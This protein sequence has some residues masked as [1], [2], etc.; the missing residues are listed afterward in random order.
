MKFS[1]PLTKLERTLGFVY[2]L[3]QLFVLPSILNLV[4]ACL[5]Q[6]LSESSLNL[7]FFCINF[8]CVVAIF[9]RFLWKSLLIAK[10]N[11]WRCLRY[12]FLGYALYYIGNILVTMGIQYL[13]PD[14]YNINDESVMSMVQE[15]FTLLSMATVF[16][17]PVVEECLFRGVMFRGFYDKSPLVAYTLS[18]LLF[19]MIHVIGYVGIYSWSTLALCYMQYLPAGLCLAW[20]YKK[21]DTIISPII[22]HMTINQLG[23]LAMR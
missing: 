5:L 11:L 13:N 10:E 2:I 12:A 4:N 18:T 7:L 23:I 9:H 6:P 16:L 15:Q 20:A 17:V 21:S 8:I 22:M 1:L 14:F 19:A 3:I